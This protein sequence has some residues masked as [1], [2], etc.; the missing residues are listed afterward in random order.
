ME[1]EPTYTGIK[2]SDTMK[3]NVEFELKSFINENLMANYLLNDE[4]CILLTELVF[5]DIPKN[6]LDNYLPFISESN[7]DDAFIKSLIDN[8]LSKY[9]M[10]ND[11]LSKQL[12][13]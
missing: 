4:I 1:I 5:Q 6:I 9:P 8:T 12:W 10:I 11:Q 7:S 3:N 13:F 2:K